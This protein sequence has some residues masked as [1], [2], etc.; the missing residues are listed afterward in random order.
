MS[1]RQKK[2]APRFSDA[3]RLR[4]ARALAEKGLAADTSI[5]RRADRS[6]PWPLSTGQERLWLAE[7]VLAGTPL[8]HVP[9]AAHLVG[10]LD[11]RALQQAL[12]AT[13]QR[14]EILRA[15][16]AL[17]DE[18]PVQHTLEN[19]ELALHPLDLSAL[20]RAQRYAQAL[21]LA[22]AEFRR[23][24]ELAKGPPVRAAL[25]KLADEEHVFLLSLH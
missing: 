16:F 7:Q 22:R 23:P 2:T 20:P 15:R 12:A 8:Y 25:W 18:R 19:V 24:F 10:P 4:L 17:E 6:G 13:V 3:A 21:A 11:V 5:A 9:L 14:H 1:E